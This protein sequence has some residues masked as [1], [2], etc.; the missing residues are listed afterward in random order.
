MEKYISIV[1]LKMSSSRKIAVVIKLETGDEIY[2]DNALLNA[3]FA[4]AMNNLIDKKIRKNMRK[5]KSKKK[6][7][8]CL[9]FYDIFRCIQTVSP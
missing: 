2:G 1:K 7:Y 5:I 6:K 3:D 8:S 4:N 9:Y